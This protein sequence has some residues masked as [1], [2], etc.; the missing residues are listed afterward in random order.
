LEF[1]KLF[2]YLKKNKPNLVK[3]A[4]SK[5]REARKILHRYIDLPRYIESYHLGQFSHDDNFGKLGYHQI[6][7]PESLEHLSTMDVE[8]YYQTSKFKHLFSSDYWPQGLI[9]QMDPS[10]LLKKQVNATDK[11]SYFIQMTELVL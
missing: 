1:Q 3:R 5:P 8:T 11:K 2:F 10:F 4:A 6:C 7:S 9:T